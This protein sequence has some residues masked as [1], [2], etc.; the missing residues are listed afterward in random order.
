MTPSERLS[1]A[2]KH[3]T[4]LREKATPGEWWTFQGTVFSG[5]D[6][7][8]SDG[9]VVDASTADTA[10]LVATLHR[11]VDPVLA[12][13][14]DEAERM[15]RDI[16][17]TDPRSQEAHYG[18]VLAVA[19]AILAEIPQ[20]VT[21]RGGRDKALRRLSALEDPVDFDDD[22]FEPTPWLGK[23]NDE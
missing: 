22:M 14:G 16:N 13:L 23:D 4:R 11:M 3:L 1:E 5:S 8:D 18:A 10:K 21:G 20:K 19:D 7:T 15:G 17:T 6:V 9:I 2:I 12:W